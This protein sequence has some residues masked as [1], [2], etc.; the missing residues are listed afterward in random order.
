[1]M[2]DMVAQ[3]PAGRIGEPADSA[4]LA[5]WLASDESAFATGQ[6]YAIDGGRTARI[7]SPGFSA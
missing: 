1:M 2:R 4:G 7:P 5:V 3:R 6:L